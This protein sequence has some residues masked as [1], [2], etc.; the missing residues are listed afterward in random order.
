M[1]LK[2]SPLLSALVVA[3]AVTLA[4]AG[5]Y[6][7]ALNVALNH[8]PGFEILTDFKDEIPLIRLTNFD[9]QILKGNYEGKQPRFLLGVD[10]TIVVPESD[11]SFYLDLGLVQ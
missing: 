1:Q 2:N 6:L 9:G 11:S 7:A 3:L 5:G 8:P 10:E 4:F